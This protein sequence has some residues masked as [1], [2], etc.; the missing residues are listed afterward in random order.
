MAL[1][2]ADR[3]HLQRLKTRQGRKKSDAFVCEGVRCCGELLAAQPGWI[4]SIYISGEHPPSLDEAL[5]NHAI[6]EVSEIDLKDVSQT[7]NPQNILIL[8]RRP[9]TEWQLKE[10]PM[11]TLVL[12]EVSDPGNMGTI[13][14]SAWAAGNVRLILQKGCCDVFEAKCIR[15]GMGAQFN[16]P[17]KKMD[18]LQECPMPADRVYVTD[19][20]DGES[21]YSDA[22]ELPGSTVVMGNEGHGLDT[23]RAENRL[24]IP[25]PGKAE[26]LNVAQA[27]G[28]II[29]ETLRRTL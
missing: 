15:A 21:L 18:S 23:S 6:V 28:L 12:S 26:S 5:E 13:F 22:I 4:E 11:L 10:N 8:A 7:D 29:F 25:M 17:Y 27:A 14:R 16:V 1:S 2:T 19:V 9:K 20:H 3:K 24:H